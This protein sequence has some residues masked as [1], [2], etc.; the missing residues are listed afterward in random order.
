MIFYFIMYQFPEISIEIAN[1]KNY[2]MHLFG[3][4]FFPAV[5]KCGGG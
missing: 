4:V 5:P 2:L 3:M 1:M